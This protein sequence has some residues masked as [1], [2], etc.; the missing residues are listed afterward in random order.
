V[1]LRRALLPITAVAAL[2]AVMLGMP[3]SDATYVSASTSTTTVT[4]ASDWTAPTVSVDDPGAAVSGTAT[5]SATALDARSGIA[6]VAVQYALADSGA[7]QTLCIDTAAPYACAWNTT[8]GSAAV[9]DGSYDLRATAVDAAGYATTSAIVTT[10]VVN[11]A[12]VVLTRLAA[13]VRGTV[14]LKATFLNAGLLRPNLYFEYAAAGSGSWMPVPGCG[15]DVLNVAN[16]RNCSWNTTALTGDYDVRAVAL[17]AGTTYRDTQVDVTVDNLAPSVALTVPPNPL[18]GTIVLTATATDDESGLASVAFQYRRSGSSSWLTCGTVTVEPWRCSLLTTTLA[19][20]TYEFQAV[21][22]D[23]AGNTTTTMLQ[24]R[25]VN[26]TISSVSLT[27]PTPGEVLRGLVTVAADAHSTAGVR[28]VTIE[29]RP[30]GGTWSGL[31]VD[32]TAPYSCGW[33]TSAIVSAGYELRAVLTDGSGATTTSAVVPVTIDNNM[34]RA[35]DV[36]VA[37][38]ATAGLP[39]AGDRITL[40][41][42]AVIDL[43]TVKAGWTGASTS[44]SVALNDKA[45]TGVPLTGYDWADLGGTNLG[46]LSF[47]QNYVRSRKTTALPATMTGSTQTVDGVPVTVVVITLGAPTSSVNLR[48]ANVTG[49]TRWHPTASV[50]TAGGVASSL[51]AAAE[52]GAVDKDF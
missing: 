30:T 4:A 2:A 51:T 38:V 20:G 44:L 17:L 5:I 34:L 48:T 33:D 50:R 32:T 1:N 40:T 25:T 49:T 36:Q 37:N 26:N 19:D 39:A 47:T 43:T 18:T 16:P 45:N 52:S 12:A 42:S 35:L 10:R 14:A 22:T 27:V 6:S 7:W 8:S 24:T 3:V 9:A 15:L 21:A 31:C 11:T 13:A 46:K 28:S 23:V 29:A 41:W